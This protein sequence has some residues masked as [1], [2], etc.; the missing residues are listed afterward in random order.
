MKR[1]EI[2]LEIFLELLIILAIIAFVG[3]ALP[4]IL[5]FLW[6]LVA[7]WL[8]ATV[9]HP[10]QKF[11]QK[12]LKVA[13]KLGS[14]ILVVFVIAIVVLAFYG[15]GS[16][17]VN[18]GSDFV[19]AV[20]GIYND[21][22]NNISS[23]WETNS[24]VLPREISSKISEIAASASSEISSYFAGKV[25]DGYL[26]SFAKSVTNGL[27]GIIVMFMSAYMFMVDWDNLYK[28][29]K[30]INSDRFKEQVKLV[31]DNI[32]A[33]VGGYIL[34]Q[35]KLMAII[36]VILFIG[37]MILPSH[38]AFV[39]ALLI[40]ILDAIPFLGVGTVLIPWA[41]YEVT[42][43]NTGYALGLMILY[44]ICLVLR[45]ILQPR[46]VGDSVGLSSLTTLVLMY[47]G[48]KL[49]GILGFILMI[50]MG[51]IVKRMYETGLFDGPIKR[52]KNRLEM[53][54]TAP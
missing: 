30:G 31:K 44:L 48:F 8:I 47:I 40:A 23:W 19:K 37:L 28:K 21:T 29:Y 32:F 34:A 46:L 5:G 18:L 17:L 39:P 43:G 53:L 36:A 6:P 2:Y 9:A 49:G 42:I 20:P 52:T 22:M 4:K 51:I 1:W 16:A 7:G 41:V 26:T 45:Q 25:S 33:G 11:L 12:R 3:L 38:Y 27:I 14:A 50:L 35:I 10:I 15:L 54:K 24:V 13:K